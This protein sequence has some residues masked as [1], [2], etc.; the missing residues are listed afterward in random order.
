MNLYV[1]FVQRMQ[2]KFPTYLI[3]VRRE[4]L[5]YSPNDMCVSPFF[6]NK[7]VRVAATGGHCHHGRFPPL[8]PLF[9]PS[10]AVV[11][12]QDGMLFLLHRPA[13]I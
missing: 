7:G 1:L 13:S 10:N 2:K 9:R 3:F 11:F 8:N 12:D 6:S 4:L 5:P